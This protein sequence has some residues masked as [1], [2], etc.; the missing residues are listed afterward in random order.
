[1]ERGWVHGCIFCVPTP[2]ARVRLGR[3]TERREKRGPPTRTA[4]GLVS[5]GPRPRPNQHRMRI[6]TDTRAP[7][8]GNVDCGWGLFSLLSSSSLPS[9]SPSARLR[10]PP[11]RTRISLSVLS[12][13]ACLP[14]FLPLSFDA[15]VNLAVSSHEFFFPVVENGLF[16]KTCLT[17]SES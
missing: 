12:A 11:S 15:S 16:T 17:K 14:L 7:R 10:L 8:D 13:S 4:G 6:P 1:M 9:S 3:G 2:P 5:R